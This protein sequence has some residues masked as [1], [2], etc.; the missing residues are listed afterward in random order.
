LR[1][2]GKLI[3]K[4]GWLKGNLTKEDLKKMMAEMLSQPRQGGRLPNRKAGLPQRDSCLPKATEANP[5]KLKVC[6]EM[7]T[8]HEVTKADAE[9]TEAGPGMMQSIKEHKEIPREKPQ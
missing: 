2:I 1:P 9:K 4:R 8:Y 5:E 3:E 6:Q 7:I